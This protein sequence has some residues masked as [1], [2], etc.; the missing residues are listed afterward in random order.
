MDIIILETKQEL[1]SKAAQTGA[2]LS[3]KAILERGEA[4]ISVATGAS[5]FEMLGELVKCSNC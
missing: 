4:N 5:Q 2:Q 1:G 3:R